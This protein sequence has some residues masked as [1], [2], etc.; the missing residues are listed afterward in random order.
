V[1]AAEEGG[2]V[3]GLDGGGLLPLLVGLVEAALALEHFGDAGVG[4]AVGGVALD[5]ALEVAHG[6]GGL[7]DAKEEGGAAL[8]DLG[9]VGVL[10][11]PAG[12]DVEGEVEGVAFTWLLGQAK[13]ASGRDA[14]AEVEEAAVGGAEA[15]EGEL[16]LGGEGAVAE[17]GGEAEVA[18][19]F[20]EDRREGEQAGVVGV[21]DEQRAEDDLG[22]G[23]EAG[24]DEG[25]G[26]AGAVVGVEVDRAW[27]R[28]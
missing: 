26:E 21:G 12:G 5:D 23:G 16:G 24:A 11:A 9:V 8:V 4:G 13:I 18:G 22:V 17:V 10:G 27:R 14:G 15:G 28:R 20:G 7:A 2:G 1:G 3:G 25:E 19:V 6:L